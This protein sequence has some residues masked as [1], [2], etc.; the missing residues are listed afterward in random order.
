M[1]K[2]ETL[3]PFTQVE[4]WG[5]LF[6]E[7]GSKSGKWSYYEASVSTQ[8]LRPHFQ[9]TEDFGDRVTSSTRVLEALN[10][11]HV[12]VCASRVPRGKPDVQQRTG[13]PAFRKSWERSSKNVLPLPSSLQPRRSL[14]ADKP[15]PHTLWLEPGSPRPTPVLTIPL[16]CIGPLFIL[17]SVLDGLS[18]LCTFALKDDGYQRPLSPWHM[19]TDPSRSASFNGGWQWV[20]HWEAQEVGNPLQHP[21]EICSEQRP[22]CGNCRGAVSCHPCPQPSSEV[23]ESEWTNEWGGDGGDLEG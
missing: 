23:C 16:C 10:L 12:W 15:S 17:V 9:R 5:Q 20:V 13:S 21:G 1:L 3:D 22:V 11:A 2:P 19:R 18:S 8:E 6:W 4:V 14:W 7:L